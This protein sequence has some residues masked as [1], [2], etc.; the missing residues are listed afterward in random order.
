MASH[1][2]GTSL[3]SPQQGSTK[4]HFKAL[5]RL[6]LLSSYKKGE[7]GA[8]Q[9]TRS[10]A[11]TTTDEQL[12]IY[13]TEIN[14]SSNHPVLFLFSFETWARRPLSQA[15]NPYASTSVQG[16]TNLSHPRWT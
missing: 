3:Q 2:Y 4:H 14:I 5:R 13:E 16:N 8:S 11:G 15:C 12:A 7:A 9:A 6:G 10:E 1:L